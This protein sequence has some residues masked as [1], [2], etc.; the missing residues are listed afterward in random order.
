MKMR[1]IYQDMS[2]KTIVYFENMTIVSRIDNL[3]LVSSNVNVKCKL[4]T[5]RKHSFQANISKKK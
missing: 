4:M 1:R 2:S 5:V 3:E